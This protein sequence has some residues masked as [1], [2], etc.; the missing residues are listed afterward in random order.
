MIKLAIPRVR[1]PTG[2]VG[3]DEPSELIGHVA[4]DTEGRAW[5][6]VVSKTPILGSTH[7]AARLN[8]ERFVAFTAIPFRPDEIVTHDTWVAEIPQRAIPDADY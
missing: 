1:R 2:K 8:F 7:G 4:F 6:L 5:G 3:P